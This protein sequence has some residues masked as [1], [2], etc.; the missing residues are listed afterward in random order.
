MSARNPA[1]VNWEHLAAS[2]VLQS[3]RTGINSGACT[4]NEAS[5]DSEAN[6]N[7]EANLEV[8]ATGVRTGTMSSHHLV[9]I[10]EKFEGNL[11]STSI[12]GIQSNIQ[13]KLSTAVNKMCFSY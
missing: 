2:K 10:P 4:D 11:L 7:S 12:Q 3:Q 9:I 8:R 1:S 6:N 5:I 13:V